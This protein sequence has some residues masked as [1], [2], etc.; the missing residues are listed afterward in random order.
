[1]ETDFDNPV[2]YSVNEL[3][4]YVEYGSHPRPTVLVTEESY[5]ELLAAY[6]ELK[7]RMEGLEK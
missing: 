5:R 1:M 6:K 3:W 7:F 2:E 4:S